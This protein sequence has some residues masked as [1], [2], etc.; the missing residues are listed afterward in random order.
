MNK[1]IDIT[2]AV[3]V[4]ELLEAYP[5][6]EEVLI[7]IAPPFKKLKNPM[8]RKTVA[9]IATLKH[10]SSVGGVSLDELIS[11][12]RDAVGQAPINESYHDEEYF[13]EQ[14]EWF[15]ADKVNLS[16]DESKQKNKNE[17]TLV[18]LLKKSKNL[19]AGEIIELVTTFLPA[20][21]IDTLRSKGY[22]AWVKKE[23]GGIIKSYFLKPAD[24][25]N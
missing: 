19:R 18:T 11:K 5:E 2:P 3:T 13:G 12:L 1:G 20:P 16:V 6:L 17:M 21:G 22:L 4:H 10:V 8:L 23:D 25:I 15:S 24:F 7:G 9:R 14:P